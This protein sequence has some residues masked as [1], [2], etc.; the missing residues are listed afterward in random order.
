VFLLS[1][2]LISVNSHAY[3]SNEDSCS[4]YKGS[5]LNLYF[6]ENNNDK[7]YFNMFNNKCEIKA[8]EKSKTLEN[9]FTN[10]YCYKYEYELTGELASSSSL[11]IH[12]SK[13]FCSE[14]N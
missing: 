1:I 3:N 6:H 10:T 9:I 11:N 12:K 4:E 5:T 8:I 13:Y 2:T 7:Y 14:D